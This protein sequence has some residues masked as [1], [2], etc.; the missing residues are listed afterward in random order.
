MDIKD[1]VS[2]GRTTSNETGSREVNFE[3]AP[4]FWRGLFNMKQDTEHTFVR[5]LDG[6]RNVRTGKLAEG[7]EEILI[8]TIWYVSSTGWGGW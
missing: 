4:T 3:T 7:D 6:W 8:V 2:Y 5:V 1:L